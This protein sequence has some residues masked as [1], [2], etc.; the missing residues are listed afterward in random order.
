MVRARDHVDHDR[1]FSHRRNSATTMLRA[2]LWQHE[3]CLARL[4]QAG[5]R[6]LGRGS[7]KPETALANSDDDIRTSATPVG[8]WQ[9]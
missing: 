4:Q 2:R 6:D 7:Y 5:A 8:S 9:R 1:D 3:L